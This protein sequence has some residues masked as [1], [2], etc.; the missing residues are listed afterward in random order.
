MIYNGQKEILDIY[1][2][3]LPI[4]EVYY[5]KLLV[6]GLIKSCYGYG[7]WVNDLPWSNEEGWVN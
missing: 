4:M 1:H 6:F 7:Y 5:G 3:T 2:G